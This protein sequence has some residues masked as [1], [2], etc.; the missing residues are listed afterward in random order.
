VKDSIVIHDP[1]A[2]R[3]LS[4]G[5][6]VRIVSAATVADVLP[7]LQILERAVNEDGLYAAGFLSY[8]A[9]PAFDAALKVRP[10]DSGFPLLWFGL[11]PAPLSTAGSPL[12]T[13]NGQLPTGPWTPSITPEEYERSLSQLRDH[14]FRGDSYQVNFTFRLRA[15]CP[16]SPESL[17]Q[18]LVLAQGAHYSAFVDTGDFVL[19]SASPELFFSLDGD[20]LVSRPMKGTQT[21]GLTLEDDLKQGQALRNS[22]KNRAENI[23][24]VDMIR[25]DMGRVAEPGSVVPESLFDVERYPTVWQMVST[26]ASR[27][28]A[29][30]SEILTALFPCASIT[31]APKPRT[32]EIIAEEETTPRRIYTGTIGYLAPGRQAQFN[33]AI[34]TVLMD[35]RSGTAEYG[36]GGGIVWDSVPGNEYA[37]CWLKAK[38]LLEKPTP[39][40]LLETL[41]WTPDDGYFLLDRHLRRLT[42]SAE[43]FTMSV[44]ASVLRSRLDEESSRFDPQSPRRVRLLV[45]PDGEIRIES[46]PFDPIAAAAR[47]PVRLAATPIDPADRFLYHKTTHRDAYDRAKSGVGD[48]DDVLLWNPAGELTESTI[49]N[50]VVE[51]DGEFITPPVR[52]GLLPG[53]YRAELLEQGIIKEAIIAVAD[54]PRCGRI[55]LVNSLR[56]WREA[57]LL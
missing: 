6:P 44:P 28:L 51:R 4:F 35:R 38:V 46:F 43:Y 2:G 17:F 41:L 45:A 16:S 55:H 52:C 27:T 13:A 53:T 48:C 22:E 21:R 11:Y 5:N 49:A 10:D 14:L 39:F 54:L 20:R 7:A 15:A 23:M 8:E 36:V 3:W 40:D 18:N 47:V 26:V 56:K 34:R 50:I 19:C 31:G 42:E 9:A 30:V 33:V 57:K 32:M 25:N 24:I 37:E 29:P 12:P 1:K